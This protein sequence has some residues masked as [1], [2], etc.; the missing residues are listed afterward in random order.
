MRTMVLIVPVL[1]TKKASLMINHIW[2]LIMFSFSVSYIPNLFLPFGVRSLA[3]E[4]E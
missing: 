3:N 2:V 1:T 4:L